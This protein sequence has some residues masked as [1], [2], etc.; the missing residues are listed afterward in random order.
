MEREAPVPDDEDEESQGAETLCLHGRDPHQVQL[1]HGR[2][3]RGG[4]ILV[5]NLECLCH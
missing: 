3:E 5:I 4:L 2:N 1:L